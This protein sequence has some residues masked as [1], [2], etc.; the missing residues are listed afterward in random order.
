MIDG[1][2]DVERARAKIPFSDMKQFLDWGQFAYQAKSAPHWR[3]ILAKT[4]VFTS[5]VHPSLW[6]VTAAG[7]TEPE[8]ERRIRVGLVQHEV[9]QQPPHLR[10]GPSQ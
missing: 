3:P 8:W 9:P 2:Y 10:M 7:T 5:R 6:Y 4:F 1:A